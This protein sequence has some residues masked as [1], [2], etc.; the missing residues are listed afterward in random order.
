MGHYFLLYKG[1]NEPLKRGVEPIK[2]YDNHSKKCINQSKS[3][4]PHKQFKN[5]NTHCDRNE[6]GKL[7]NRLQ[8]IL[9]DL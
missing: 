2:I 6:L 7:N 1:K 8:N 3:I 5:T 9:K 4:E